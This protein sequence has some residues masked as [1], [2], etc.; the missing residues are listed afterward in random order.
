MIDGPPDNAPTPNAPTPDAS[1][2]GVPVLTDADRMSLYE[3]NQGLAYSAKRQRSLGYS[4]KDQEDLEQLALMGLWDAAL[5]YDPTRA[6]FSTFAHLIIHQRITQG[7]LKDPN[8]LITESL[9][10]SLDGDAGGLP[11]RE[12]A[13]ALGVTDRDVLEERDDIEETNEE[14]KAVLKDISDRRTRRWVR[15]YHLNGHSY[16]KIAADE[17]LAPGTIRNAVTKAIAGVRS[18]SLTIEPA[19]NVNPPSRN[20]SLV[21]SSR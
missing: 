4:E 21:N 12:A 17:G 1:T 11:Y 6:K 10:A 8:D 15:R 3:N 16:E 9:D 7:M 2:P 20:P 18:G 14:L 13:H 5:R 19:P